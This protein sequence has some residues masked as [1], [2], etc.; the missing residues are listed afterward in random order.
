M[1]A[2]RRSVLFTIVGD[3]NW[4]MSVYPKVVFLYIIKKDVPILYVYI[5]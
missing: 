2:N 3:N 4:R 1:F 5:N